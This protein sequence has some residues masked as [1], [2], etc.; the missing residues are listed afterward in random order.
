MVQHL[1]LCASMAGDMGL[2]PGLGTKILK[3][4]KAQLHP[5]TQKGLGKDEGV[6]M[7]T[8]AVSSLLRC[9]EPNAAK[10]ERGAAC[11]L[12]AL[13]APPAQPPLPGPGAWGFP[14]GCQNVSAE[15]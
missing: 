8:A 1:R 12:R 2:I 6:G 9:S 7:P 14:V 15:R 10:A 11:R 5:P 4:C 13:P 3:C